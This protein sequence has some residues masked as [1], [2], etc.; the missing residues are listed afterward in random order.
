M[1]C[2]TDEGFSPRATASGENP[3]PSEFAADT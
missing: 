1:K 2:A 3:S